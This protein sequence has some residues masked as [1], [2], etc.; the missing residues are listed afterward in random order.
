[1]LMR[2]FN[3]V[4]DIIRSII[5]YVTKMGCEIVGMDVLQCQLRDM[6]QLRR[7][8]LVLDDVWS[9]DHDEWDKLSILL[10]DCAEGCFSYGYSFSLLFKEPI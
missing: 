5:E 9:E 6:L 4:R 2:I 3:Y 10:S 8:L 1:M 7:C